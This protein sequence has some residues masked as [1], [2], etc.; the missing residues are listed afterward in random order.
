[1]RFTSFVVAPA[2]GWLVRCLGSRRDQSASLDTISP[3]FRLPRALQIAGLIEF[4]TQITLPSHRRACTPPGCRL[5]A[6]TLCERRSQKK[7]V[8]LLCG[9]PPRQST[10]ESFGGRAWLYML[11][12][13]A[14]YIQITPRVM[15][16]FSPGPLQSAG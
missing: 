1:M 7:L 8:S 6:V 15:F 14:R 5:W 10:D 2:Q 13:G 3:P 11:W 9:R 12:P 4:L 16:S